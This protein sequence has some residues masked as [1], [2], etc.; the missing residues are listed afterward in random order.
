MDKDRDLDSEWGNENNA[1]A[2]Y[3][4]FARQ[5]LYDRTSYMGNNSYYASFSTVVNRGPQN[6]LIEFEEKLPDDALKPYGTTKFATARKDQ[7]TLFLID[8]KNRDRSAYPQPT[9]FTLKPPRVYQNVASIQVTEIKLLSSFFYFRAAKGNTFLPVIERGRENINKFLGFPLTY[10]V[11]VAEGS[12]NI[13]DLLNT[14]QIQMNYTPLFYDYPTGFAGFVNAFTANGDLSV[15]FNQPGDTYYDALNKKYVTNPT[16]D[17]IT[18]YYWGSRYAGLTQYTVDQVKV[19]Y[20]YPVLYEVFLDTTDTLVYPFLNLNLTPGL[21][22]N[23]DTVYTHIIFNSTG[24]NDPILL[25]LIDQN[26]TLLDTYRL[27]H[28]FRFYLINRYQVAYDSNSLRVNIVTLS[29]NTSLINLIN[30]TNARNLTTIIQNIGLTPQTFS[31]TSNTLNQA[32][33]VFADMYNYIQTQLTTYFAVNYATYAAQYFLNTSNVIFI[34]NGL[35]AEGVRTGYT[36]EYLQSGQQPIASTVALYSNS[37]GYWPN[38][39]SAN[40]YTA[41]MRSPLGGGIN[42]EGINP[43]TSMVPYSVTSSNFQ[44]GLQTIDTSDYFI[45]TSRAT[46]S[47][48]CVATI[49]PAQYTVFKFRSQVRQTLQ[50]E[51]L[52]LPYYYRFAGYNQQGFIKGILDP[53]NSNVPQIYFSTP[54]EFLYQ[55]TNQL[56]DSSNYNTTQLQD[57][58]SR[59]FQTAF[60]SSPVLSLNVQSNFAQFE[61]IAPWPPGVVSTGIYCYNT[62]LSFIGVNPNTPSISTTLGTNVQAYVYHD[63]GAFMADLA[64]PYRRKENPLNYIVSTSATTASSDLTVQIS[65]FAG[66]RYY[67]IFRSAGL[68]FANMSYRPVVYTDTNY[69]NI[70]T[71]YL[72]FSPFDNPSS[73]SNL[74][75]FPFVENYNSNYLRLPIGST[76]QGIDPSDPKYSISV[77]VKGKPIGYDISGVSDDLTDY[78]GYI[79]GQPG[80]IPDT[81][82]RIDPTS[83]FTFQAISP[84][85]PVTG[86]YF[87]PGTENSILEPQ[88]N[89][90]YTYQ[91][92]KASQIKIV[93]WYDDYFIPKQLDD[94]I[95]TTSTI[96]FSRY[97]CSIQD[98]VTGYPLG[99]DGKIEFGRGVN[100]I[101]FL[102]TDGVYN[103]SSFTFK[104]A[105]YPLGDVQ[106]TVEDPNTAIKYIGVFTGSYLASKFIAIS[107]AVTV[108]SFKQALV[109]GPSTIEYTPGFGVE[110]GTWYEFGYDPS[111]VAESNVK[112]NGYT[113]S[114]NE[115]VSYDSMYYMVPFNAEGSNLTFTNLTGSLLPYPLTQ[116]VSTGSSYFGQTVKSIV[117]TRPQLQYI[118]PSTISNPFA[119]YGP[120]GLVPYTQSQYEQSQPIMTNSIGFREFQKLVTNQYALFPFRTTFSNTQ[121]SITSNNVGLTTFV[122]EYYDTLYTVNSLSNMANISNILVTNQG[123]TYASSISTSISLRGGNLSSMQFLLNA[124]STLNN[125]PYIG[126]SNFY[127][128]FLFQNMDANGTNSNITTRKLDIDLNVNTPFI[129]AWLW[130]A[131]GGTWT[132]GQTATINQMGGAG[133]YAKVRINIQTLAQQ[134]GVSSLY[135]VVGKGGNRDNVTFTSNGS[136][137]FYEQPRYGGGGTSLIETDPDSPATN[138]IHT[139]GGGFT[140]L[141]LGSNLTS[142]L[143]L[144]IVGGGGA[145]GAYTMGG[146]GGFGV[147]PIPLPVERFF[148]SNVDLTTLIYDEITITSAI[149]WSAQY[150][151]NSPNKGTS[152]RTLPQSYTQDI[153]VATSWLVDGDYGTLDIPRPFL[154]SQRYTNLNGFVTKFGTLENKSVDYFIGLNQFSVNFASNISSIG[155]VRVYSTQP[156]SGGTLPLGFIVYNDINKSQMLY[157]NFDWD[158]TGSIGTLLLSNYWATPV[159]ASTLTQVCYEL[160]ITQEIINTPLVTSGWVACG[161]NK[162]EFDT[163]QY[164]LDGS[165]WVNIRSQ[166]GPSGFVPLTSTTSVVFSG[167]VGN[168]WY[169][170]G[171]NTILRSSNGLDWSASGITNPYTGGS[172]NTLVVGSNYM[173]VGG[174]PAAGTSN[175]ILRTT[176]GTSWSNTTNSFGFNVTNLRYTIPLV[177]AISPIASPSLKYSSTGESWTNI[178]TGVGILTGARDIAFD[179]LTTYV[180]AMGTGAAPLNSPL[181][182]G[183]AASIFLPPT[184]WTAAFNMNLDNFTCNSVCYGNGVFVAGG[185]TS[186]GTSPMKWSAD[187]INWF[188]TDVIPQT[189]TAKTSAF[190][191]GNIPPDQVH[192]AG[193]TRFPRFYNSR[194]YD[195]IIYKITFDVDSNSFLSSGRGTTIFFGGSGNNQLSIM[196]S[197]NGQNWSLS[198]Q[199]GYNNNWDNNGIIASAFSGSYGPLTII[200]NLST[201]YIEIGTFF[202]EFSLIAEIEVYSKGYLLPS[203]TASN[204]VSTIY[205]NKLATYWW[206]SED[207]VASKSLTNYTLTLGF[208]TP[209]TLLSKLRFYTPNDSTRYF[210]GL[211]MGLD[212]SPA[213]AFNNPSISPIEFQYDPEN[214]VS[215]YDAIFIPP[216]SNVSTIYM[217]INKTTPT[218]LQINE[219]AAENDPNKPINIFK[220]DTIIFVAARTD[221]VPDS[222]EGLPGLPITNMIDGNLATQWG[223]YPRPNPGFPVSCSYELNFHFNTPIARINFIQFY[224][225]TFEFG[226][227]AAGVSGVVVY[228]DSNKGSILYSNVLTAQYTSLG[229]NQYGYQML[230]FYILPYTDVSDIY[231]EFLNNTVNNGAPLRINE[232]YFVNIGLNLDTPAGYTGGTITAMQRITVPNFLYDGGGGSNGIGGLGGADMYTSNAGPNIVASNGV[233]GTYLKGGSPASAGEN[234]ASYTNILYGAGGGGGGYYGGGGGGIASYNASCNVYEGGAGGGGAGYFIPSTNLITLLE[235][236]VAV[237]GNVLTQTSSNYFPPKKT[238]QDALI[239]SNQMVPYTN[240]LGYGAG[241]I[242]ANDS[243]QGAHGAIVLNF[244]APAV[245]QPIGRASQTPAFVDGSKLS[246]FQAPISY[247]SDTRILPFTAYKDPI[248]FSPFSNYNWVWYKSYLDLTGSTLDPKTMKATTQIPEPPLRKYPGLPAIVYTSIEDQFYNVSSFFNGRISTST[249][250]IEGLEVSFQLFNQ[251]FINTPYTDPKYTTYTQVYCLL[252]YL[253]GQSNLLNPHVDSITSP[254]NRIFGGLPGF[255]YWANPFLTNVSYVGFDTGPSL[256]PSFQLSTICGSSDTVTAFY[257][258]ALEQDMNTGIY[259]MKN[260]IAYKPTLADASNHGSNWL[261]VT[262][263]NESYI[264]NSLSNS[265]IA[266]NIPVQPY[267]LQSAI[268]GNLPLLNYKVYTAPIPVGSKVAD[269]PIQMINDFQGQYAYLYT[270]QNFNQAD[271]STVHFTQVPLT[272]SII[273]VNQLNITNLS[274]AAS[275]IIGTVVSENYGASGTRSTSLLAV[276]QFGFN[277][278][279]VNPDP[280]NPIINFNTGPSNYYN[281]YSAN[282]PIQASN[283][284]KG[285]TDYIGNL[286]VTDRLGSSNLYENVCTIQIFQQPFSNQNMKSA[287]PSLI[288][289]EY[290]SGN[291]N[292]YYDYLVSRSQNVWQIQGTQ[293]LS[294]IFG[295]RLISPYDFT[296]TTNFANQI[297]YPTH[298]IILNKTATGTNPIQNTTDLTNYPSFTK[299]QSFFYNNF[300]SLVQDISGQFGLEKSSNFEFADTEFAGYF[301]NSYIQNI[302]MAASTNFNNANKDSFNYLAIRA[303]SPSESFKCLVRFYLPGRYDFGY[304]SLKDLSNEILTLQSNTNVNPDYLDVLGEFTSSFAITRVFGG[305]GLPGYSGS[306]I[307]TVTFGDFLSKYSSVQGIITSNSGT[308]NTVINAVLAGQK[309]LI[310]GDLQYI[311]PA[312]VATRERV[313][314]PLEFSLPFSTIAQASNR[315]IEEYGMGYNLGF[316]QKDTGFNT[317]QRAGS[318]FKILDDYIYMKMNPEHNMNRLD[319]SRQEDY[320][321]S[322]DTQAESRLYNC[323]LILNNFGTYAT[324][325]VQNPVLFN[326]PIG[327]LDKLIFAWYDRTGALINNDECE[328]SGSIQVVETVDVATADS[329]IPKM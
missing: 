168:R 57:I 263:F 228:T 16:M 91:G 151:D 141:F 73:R 255:G 231:I 196:R 160:P 204:T 230:A 52:P 33:V 188:D 323:K 23:G 172:L 202:T 129:T 136:I 248:Q 68:S 217:D 45:Q 85:D 11:Q 92:T 81:I 316:S 257:G 299:T 124:P 154:N 201:L 241:A 310:T 268:G 233:S 21:L 186:D 127:S 99:S 34:Q 169:A 301:F 93:H 322:H 113:Q 43:S 3:A 262:Q 47:V 153:A 224:T 30:L 234:G 175:S 155:K 270:F 220:P 104:S 285:L 210:T 139:Q 162:S 242:Q 121:G 185:S 190:F 86:S 232:I 284:G 245:V 63:R 39:I 112:I 200:P 134:Y 198:F 135:M 189:L 197:F 108:L 150:V 250:I 320:S 51:T 272:S 84:F 119:P 195:I 5:L 64:T 317:N 311:I 318:F 75:N 78:R 184:V 46:R 183:T 29:L 110:L 165:N 132:G 13:G 249:P 306:N 41:G 214:N 56:M 260:I 253:R 292:P 143:P 273:Q 251:Y 100:A 79:S 138:N 28:T 8:S 94:N 325:V 219:V 329:L 209:Q 38:F 101:G 25:I 212:T 246:L 88:T 90:V 286:F 199:G 106:P 180:V 142:A 309:A 176:N 4:S 37:P 192:P 65:T 274:N 58:A 49:H 271:L 152:L 24:L 305:V 223:A 19:A 225:N 315:T 280:L 203:Q 182:Y 130:G 174:T 302:N 291:S 238:V 170:C 107:S 300:S 77:S 14:L 89:E 53:N 116:V 158:P 237:P 289:N 324:T 159:Q 145:G 161:V 171:S 275:N 137:Q 206:P 7:T 244:D 122:S 287:S 254:L 282:S 10:N 103:V 252:D 236:G 216:L 304:I 18:S 123:A 157:S 82:F 118:T 105:I 266:S 163:L 26:I 133:A 265:Y 61:F 96:G 293:N 111:F 117:G 218:S 1:G 239:G 277:L 48:D 147:T 313:Y 97:V 50:V 54:Y 62:S 44:F 55:S 32:K 166:T 235:Y 87:D 261:K 258:L 211:T 98:Y 70:R 296:V 179:G 321:V 2:N 298:K 40:T 240:A 276:T 213:S 328:W 114:S 42:L 326:P 303:Y 69:V 72:D 17:Q 59:P 148:L 83:Q 156:T 60:V 227:N 281:K 283:V 80:F 178:A 120:Q 243:G 278:D 205:D 327:K 173:L 294:T 308:I 146:P 20:Y 215:Y 74:T 6:A 267:T 71:D 31:N 9:S 27:H 140:G 314:D 181:V 221:G 229:V 191:E 125:Y 149:D 297:F 187:G 131:G 295:A 164:S 319:I 67:S 36:T 247:E 144:I 15:N 312:Y 307:T 66:Q 269:A 102:P 126:L 193:T 207:T 279:P 35:N 128:T 222:T 194:L 288:L 226:F 177:W 208:S 95:T 22:E 290:R 12:Y 115:L 76:L 259:T 264:V 256:V 109:Y 167:A